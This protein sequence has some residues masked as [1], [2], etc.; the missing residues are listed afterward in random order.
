[1]TTPSFTLPPP[2]LQPPLYHLEHC[3][4]WFE[5]AVPPP[6]AAQRPPLPLPHHLPSIPERVQTARRASEKRAKRSGFCGRL[7]AVDRELVQRGERAR[8][9]AVS[10]RARTNAAKAQKHAFEQFEIESAYTYV[11]SRF[12]VFGLVVK[13]FINQKCSENAAT[14]VSV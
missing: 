13:S 12:F 2:P 9:M 5:H 14:P 4:R 3:Y 11:I 1:M 10:L 7:L 6:R 8:L